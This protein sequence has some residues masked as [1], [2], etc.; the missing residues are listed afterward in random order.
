MKLF[1]VLLDKSVKGS[2]SSE[3]KIDIEKVRETAKVLSETLVGNS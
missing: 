1:S 3:E 2:K